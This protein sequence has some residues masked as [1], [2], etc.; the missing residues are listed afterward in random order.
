VTT[1]TEENKIKKMNEGRSST[2]NRR[3]AMG[4][5]LW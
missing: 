1:V 2:H 4:T 3:D 5:V